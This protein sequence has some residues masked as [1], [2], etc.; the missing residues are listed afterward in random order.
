MAD[1]KLP[2]DVLTQEQRESLVQQLELHLHHLHVHSDDVAHS[3]KK[4]GVWNLL[5]E[6]YD[7]L[8]A[9]VER[10][11]ARNEAL[12]KVAKAVDEGACVECENC[13]GDGHLGRSFESGKLV[14]CEK[15][16]GHE[17]SLGDGFVLSDDLRAA[18]SAL[19]EPGKGGA[20]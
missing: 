14:A 7:R 11:R 20:T 2:G 19:A 4:C 10:L 18:L 16:G 13:G 17:D 12:E 1:E 6:D 8:V 3:L 15:C 9:K 5:R